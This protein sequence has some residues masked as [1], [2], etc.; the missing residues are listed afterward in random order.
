M[1]VCVLTLKIAPKSFQSCY[2]GMSQARP[3]LEELFMA[4]K[5]TFLKFRPWWAIF[6]PSDSLSARVLGN[7]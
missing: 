6:F 4:L 7:A 3:H 5:S 2:S 1:V